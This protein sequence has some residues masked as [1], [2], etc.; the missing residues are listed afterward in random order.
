MSARD[1]FNQQDLAIVAVGGLS[2]WAIAGL[3]RYA[4]DHA[5]MFRAAAAQW[6]AS[7]GAVSWWIA[8]PVCVG[9]ALAIRLIH[10]KWPPKNFLDAAAVAVLVSMAA[11]AVTAARFSADPYLAFR[12]GIAAVAAVVAALLMYALARRVS[13]A[14]DSGEVRRPAA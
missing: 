2:L 11:L 8:L 4:L 7:D 13:R 12:S 10:R 9:A 6:R 1:S 5:P 3:G 14:G